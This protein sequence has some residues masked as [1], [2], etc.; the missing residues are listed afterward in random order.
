M[1]RVAQ[2]LY[3]QDYMYVKIEKVQNFLSMINQQEIRHLIRQ[4]KKIKS[5]IIEQAQVYQEEKAKLKA[6]NRSLM[7]QL[8]E[9]QKR[10]RNII[11]EFNA[12][13][14][15]LE[16]ELRRARSNEPTVTMFT[17]PNN[18]KGTHR[19][20]S[21]AQLE[22]E[23]RRLAEETNRIISQTT[24]PDNSMY[25]PPPSPPNLAFL[26]VHGNSSIK[27]N[28]N[29]EQ[30]FQ[31]LQ[32]QYSQQPSSQQF[33]YSQQPYS[34]QFSYSQQPQTNLPQN[35]FS[36]G[37][38]SQFADSQQSQMQRS[39]QYQQYQQMQPVQQI[40]QPPPVQ[41]MPPPQ[42]I[43]QQSYQSNIVSQTIQNKPIL[44]QKN[45]NTAPKSQNVVKLNVPP[46]IE[47]P[48]QAIQE[49]P[50]EQPPPLKEQN[51]NTQ[52]STQKLSS[53][54]NPI[55]NLSSDSTV[56][57]IQ[58]TPS[59]V[60][61]GDSVKPSVKPNQQLSKPTSNFPVQSQS[62]PSLNKVAASDKTK[63]KVIKKQNADQSDTPSKG[64]SKKPSQSESMPVI[65]SN[66]NSLYQDDIFANLEDYNFDEG[67]GSFDKTPPKEANSGNKSLNN[68]IDEAKQQKTQTAGKPPPIPSK[69]KVTIIS[70]SG[71]DWNEKSTN[72]NLASEFDLNL[73]ITFDP[74]VSISKPDEK[75]EEK[76]EEKKETSGTKADKSLNNESSKDDNIDFDNIS[77]N[78]GDDLGFM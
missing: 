5:K 26:N 14:T 49:S 34:P 6:I 44:I 48:K 19:P 3:K 66:E 67:T 76:P 47:K 7:Q 11:E 37:L 30:Q 43:P 62:S 13:I 57:N 56:P 20:I 1:I 54:D 15:A 40:Q 59:Q 42:T 33:S 17:T 32:Q 38:G 60:S 73:D 52:S 24:K 64:M 61:T 9:E 22:A 71:N 4:N 68:S 23:S 16:A 45:Q 63:D 2:L 50:K 10:N 74:S 36:P 58:E 31:T 21:F 12:Q 8:E 27:Q 75:P 78:W 53:S 28:Y 77:I 55:L 72:S 29:K 69:N 41:Q 70:E 46:E 65:I 39:Q 25:F 18:R 35:S 51:E